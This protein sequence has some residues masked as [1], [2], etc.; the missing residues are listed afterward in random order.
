MDLQVQY[1]Y[2]LREGFVLELSSRFGPKPKPGSM[3]ATS[4][5]SRWLFIVHSRHPVYN[6]TNLGLG[7]GLRAEGLGFRFWGLGFWAG[8]VQWVRSG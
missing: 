5:S 2:D 8:T 7:L 4:L 6:H 1:I 3:K